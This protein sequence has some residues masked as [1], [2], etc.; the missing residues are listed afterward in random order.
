MA[1]DDKPFLCYQ[2]GC[3]MVSSQLYYLINFTC[4][5]SHYTCILYLRKLS[6]MISAF[7]TLSEK[8]IS[9]DVNIYYRRTLSVMM[10][11]NTIAESCHNVIICMFR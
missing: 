4:V 1:E 5:S 6:D 3:G 11:T 2:P 8:L 9:H 7:C 10:S